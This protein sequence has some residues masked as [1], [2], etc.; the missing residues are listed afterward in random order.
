MIKKSVGYILF[1]LACLLPIQSALILYLTNILNFNPNLSLWKEI[2]VSVLTAIF[3]Y[4]IT[5]GIFK[6]KIKF[7][8][9][10]FWPVLVFLGIL[11]LALL[12]LVRIIPSL[13]IL[14]FRF[15]LFWLGFFS[16][17]VVWIKNVLLS[18]KYEYKNWLN[19]ILQWGIL[20]GF[21]L[22]SV[23]S[24]LSLI[25]G[26]T[27]FLTWFGYG[28]EK[29]GFIVS[30]PA[31]HVVD[32]GDNALRLSGPFSTPNHYAGYLLL[33]VGFLLFKVFKAENKIQ[34]GIFI[35]L[36]TLNLALTFLTFARFAWLSLVVGL[37]LI[38]WLWFRNI[39]LDKFN[40]LKKQFLSKLMIGLNILVV[41]TTLA[42]PLFI[43]LVVINS[44]LENQTFLPNA[45][46]KPSSTDLHRRHFLASVDV[47]MARPSN[48]LVGL[49]LG[50]S[51]PAAKIEYGN[52]YNS[53]VVKYYFPFASKWF[54]EDK[55]LV[56]PENWFLQVWIN[57]GI[58]YL[59]AYLSIFLI[60]VYSLFKNFKI[61]KVEWTNL[62]F[63]LGYL[64]I[65]IGCLF[66]HILE[67]QTIA[68]MYSIIYIFWQLSENLDKQ[69][70]S[71]QSL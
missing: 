57:G 26:Q 12:D 41:G 25:I 59:I 38:F 1:A 33:V 34:R 36:L 60:P 64:G 47:L 27:K 51:G 15:E 53:P 20:A 37:A 29:N 58:L 68:F 39:I 19:N 16:L 5:V 61:Q 8:N 63:T 50:S 13:W 52:L 48:Y 32:F 18:E 30:S 54:I 4:Q 14:G 43:G 17:T 46:L 11:F 49:G 6:K 67:N 69:S 21:A 9:K 31:G 42:V 10:V 71:K 3:V 7:S 56:I 23:F 40:F 22:S 70:L 55:D 44:N 66:L 65:F 35:S 45:I 28:L 24:V 62:F 2:L